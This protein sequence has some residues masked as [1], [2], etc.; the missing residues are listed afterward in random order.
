[1]SNPI[2]RLALMTLFCIRLP[3]CAIGVKSTSLEDIHAQQ[4]DTRLLASVGFVLDDEIYAKQSK[5]F[6]PKEFLDRERESWIDALSGF[7]DEKN[8]FIMQKGQPVRIIKPPVRAEPAPA[9]QSRAEIL[10]G[11]L[12]TPPAQEDSGQGDKPGTPIV[13]Y[14]EFAKTHPIVHVHII[15]DPEKYK[16]S[17]NDALSQTPLVISFF[18]FWVSPAKVT[19]PYTASFSLLMPEERN[20]PPTQWEYTYDRKEFYWLP[21]MPVA[22]SSIS[23]DGNPQVD[24]SWQIEEKRRLVLKFLEDAKSLLQQH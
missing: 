16:P 24:I 1:M 19:K 22:E 6:I 7:T 11:R 12:P 23:I 9:V 20:I 14:A 2:S 3:G 17:G 5:Q 21:L 13:S 10:S 18:T 15:A 4:K 8:I